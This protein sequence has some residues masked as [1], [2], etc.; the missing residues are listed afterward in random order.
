MKIDII[1]KAIRP[2]FIFD[3]EGRKSWQTDELME[4]SK[5]SAIVVFIGICALY[6]IDKKDVM[7]VLGIDYDE[8]RHKLNMYSEL[9]EAASRKVMDGSIKVKSYGEDRA[10][11]FYYKN[12]LCMNALRYSL[13][14]EYISIKHFA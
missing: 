9:S 3:A 14:K 10:Q 11:R 12:L 13:G 2:Q 7:F 1:E 4:G 5:S 6:N 8:Y